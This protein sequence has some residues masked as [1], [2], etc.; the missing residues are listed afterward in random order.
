MADNGP[1]DEKLKQANTEKEA[2]HYKVLTKEEYDHLMCY[3]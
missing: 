3:V 2:Q 1:V